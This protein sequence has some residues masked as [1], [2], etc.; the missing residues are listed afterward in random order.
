[1]TL[2]GYARVSSGDQDHAMQREVLTA[3]GCVKIFSETASGVLCERPEL[4]RLL[5][6]LRS[7]DTLVVWKLDRLGRSIP[8]LIEVATDLAERDVGFRS[9]NEGFD[10]TTPGGRLLF[11]VLGSLARFERDLIRERTM[12]GLASARAAGRV[13]GRRPK[14]TDRQIETA[15]KMLDSGEHTISAIAEF[16]GVAR[17]TVYRVLEKPA[18]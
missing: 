12:A 8:H 10:T 5:E 13:G 2:V 17:S 7:G 18:G 14:L 1:M 3:A 11:H 9:L 4:A 6:Y 16:L 15:R